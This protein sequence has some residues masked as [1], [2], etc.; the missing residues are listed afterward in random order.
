VLL[1]RGRLAVS[2]GHHF[3]LPVEQ[4]NGR[5]RLNHGTSLPLLREALRRID[6][7]IDG[8]R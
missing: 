6:S 1:D 5:I 2:P 4:G 7:T 8:R 3:A